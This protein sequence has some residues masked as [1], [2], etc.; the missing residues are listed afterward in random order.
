MAEAEKASG[1]SSSNLTPQIAATPSVNEQQFMQQQPVKVHPGSAMATTPDLETSGR[2]WHTASIEASKSNNALTELLNS[3]AK[4]LSV[5]IPEPVLV[6]L[7]EQFL[8][9]IG[10]NNLNKSLSDLKLT[11][12][13][14]TW[15]S[16][17]VKEKLSSLQSW[18]KKN[19]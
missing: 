16:Q 17:V 11:K 4:S 14:M 12:Q 9:S 15:K 5:S 3:M 18:V 8:K 7:E 2:Q 6:P 10:V 13:F 19:K 1:G